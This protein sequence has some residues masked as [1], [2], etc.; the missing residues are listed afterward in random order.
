MVLGNSET[1]YW[2]K[3]DTYAPALGHLSL[4]LLVSL[5]VE[6]RRLLKQGDCQNAFCHHVLPPDK[7]V[8]IKPPHG[9]PISKPGTYLRLHK[10]LS[11]LCWS[12]R[13]W[14]TCF[15][16]VLLSLGLSQCPHE[17]FIFF[18]SPMT[19]SSTLYVGINVEDFAYF[20]VSDGVMNHLFT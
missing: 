17:P 4:R 16:D 20:S 18:G 11:G 1:T 2:S 10:T 14:F 5:A 12:P 8:V 13:H 7:V 9:C 6:R 3:S 15:R 19:S